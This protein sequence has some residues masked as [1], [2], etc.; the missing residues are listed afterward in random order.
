MA[1]HFDRCIVVSAADANHMR[2][3]VPQAR[4]E[5]IPSGVDTE[6]FYPFPDA[7]EEQFSITLTG[8]FDWKPKQQS[9]H[10]LLTGV[11]PRIKAKVAEAR[12]YVVGKGI[13]DHLRHVAE[14]IPGVV[15]IGAVPDVRP[16][17]AR[18]A[19]LINY[20]ESGGGIAL[21]VLE[22]MAMRKPVLCNAL[23]CEGIPM[24]HGRDI[25]VADSPDDFA[26][27]AA[28]LLEDQT[29]RKG[30]AGEGY[31]RVLEDYSWNV[32]AQRLQ[33]CY[34]NVC[35]DHR[36]RNRVATTAGE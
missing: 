21:K 1:T 7:K 13:P 19:L 24:K 28:Y 10:A 33:D 2:A 15:I 8:S 30:L 18:S 27:A 22:A 31:R 12:L 5:V 25:F 29:I 4:I 6:Y 11:F 32:I 36:S 14:T 35:E 3:I 34:L 20:L 16:Y 17:I 9:L 23:G 26:A